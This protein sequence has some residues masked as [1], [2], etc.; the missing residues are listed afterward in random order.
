M[1]LSLSI[2]I[3]FTLSFCTEKKHNSVGK[4]TTVLYNNEFSLDKKY[5]G[6][7]LNDYGIIL[8]KGN[9]IQNINNITSLLLHKI[10][11]KK[12]E[13]REWEKV[14][15]IILDSS[16][17]KVAW[18]QE[19]WTIITDM[20]GIICQDQKL[21]YSLF[22]YLNRPIFS[23]YIQ[24]NTGT[25]ALS[26]VSAE[27]KRSIFMQEGYLLHFGNPLPEEKNINAK[28][29]FDYEEIYQLAKKLGYNWYKTPQQ[30]SYWILQ[31]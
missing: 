10:P 21:L 18:Y 8:I 16:N 31:F 24:K 25:F 2:L 12:T 17:I 29:K 20:D 13:A 27:A 9:H 7:V 30:Q 26:Y 1:K 3:L 15:P 6:N 22:T 5:Y 23:I 28:T 11:S 14:I 4:D 19:G